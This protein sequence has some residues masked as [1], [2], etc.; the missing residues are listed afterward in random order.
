M[1]YIFECTTQY[2]QGEHSDQ[3]R[4]KVEHEKRYSISTNNHYLLYGHADKDMTSFWRFPTTFQR[5]PKILQKLCEG[6]SNI[7]EH[8]PKITKDF[9]RMKSS[10]GWKPS[11]N[12]QMYLH[13]TVN[14]K[15]KS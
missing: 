8:F 9:Q 6:H 7:S 15:M 13:L 4:Y 11:K 10:K 2:L 14:K 5:F 1:E 3:V 12:K